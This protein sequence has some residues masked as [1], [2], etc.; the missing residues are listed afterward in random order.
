ME[1]WAGMTHNLTIDR[2]LQLVQDVLW[3]NLLSPARF[4]DALALLHLRRLLRS[5]YVNTALACCGDNLCAIA[6]RAVRMNLA[7]NCSRD[8]EIIE[9]IWVSI[10][11]YEGDLALGMVRTVLADTNIGT[12]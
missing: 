10:E 4:S 11:R 12:H 6:V 3:A 1:R 5:K 7:R 9:R 2:T 8:R